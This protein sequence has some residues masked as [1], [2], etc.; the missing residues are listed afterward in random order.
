MC[1]TVFMFFVS[2]ACSHD[3][4]IVIFGILGENCIDIG[5]QYYCW[6]FFRDEKITK[7]RKTYEK[8]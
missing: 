8:I 6:D 3:F 4:L 5:V 1:F 2:L 7:I